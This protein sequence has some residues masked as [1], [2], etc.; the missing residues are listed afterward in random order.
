VIN[1]RGENT[2][3]VRYI[4]VLAL[5]SMSTIP[6]MAEHHAMGHAMVA[7]GAAAVDATGTINAV[8]PGNGVVNMTH[9]PIAAL[10]WPAMTM[11]FKLEDKA[12]AGKLKPGQAVKFKL[13]KVGQTDYVISAI[14]P[15]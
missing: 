1:Q 13:K 10:G 9:A 12:S 5:L 15:K 6:A 4:A 2:M 8:D 14:E 11:D 7:Q 3:K